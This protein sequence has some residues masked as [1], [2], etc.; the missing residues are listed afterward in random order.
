MN[1][2]YL[3]VVGLVASAMTAGAVLTAAP[4]QADTGA[5]VFLA[6]LR[7]SGIDIVDDAAAV[8]VGQSVCPLL[9]EPGQNAAN[10]A[11]EVADALGRP[12]GPATIFTGLAIQIFCPRAVTALT[13]GRPFSFFG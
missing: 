6:A 4:A 10:V 8:R 1:L 9:V 13:D 11:A 2:T 7:D 5:D 3:A 12:L